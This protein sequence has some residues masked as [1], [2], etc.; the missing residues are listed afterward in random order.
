MV[1]TVAEMARGTARSGLR[2]RSITEP[3]G[4]IAF[5]AEIPIRYCSC[6]SSGAAL[7]RR[8]ASREHARLAVAG[9]RDVER[10][11]FAREHLLAEGGEAPDRHAVH[12]HEQVARLDA[13]LGRRHVRADRSDQHHGR[14]H[15]ELREVAERRDVTSCSCALSSARRATRAG[16]RCPAAPR[17]RRAANAVQS[18]TG[19]PAGATT[20][21]PECSPP[22]AAGESSDRMPSV[23]LCR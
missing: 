18:A 1:S 11:A 10:L 7:P 6:G 17:R 22:V 19:A 12:R 4:R 3:P 9:D 16:S 8:G 21:S 2:T 20:R 14:N 15:A 5:T 23:A 13:R